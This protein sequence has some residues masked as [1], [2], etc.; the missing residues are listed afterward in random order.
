MFI[1]SSSE[2]AFYKNGKF[3]LYLELEQRVI[4][5]EYYIVGS[6]GKPGR[7]PPVSKGTSPLT[8]ERE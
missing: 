6:T 8:F 3:C 2:L 1:R 7:S 4:E 5:F